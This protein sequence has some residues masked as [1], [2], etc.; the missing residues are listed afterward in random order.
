VGAAA[1]QFLICP[2]AAVPRPLTDREAV[3]FHEPGKFLDLVEVLDLLA[4]SKRRQQGFDPVQAFVECHC[5][6][7]WLE[8]LG[9]SAEAIKFLGNGFYPYRFASRRG[10]T[11]KP[12]LQV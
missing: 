12:M 8:F 10:R 3:A 1:G 6:I 7:N 2:D 4:A 9:F 5:V 11:D